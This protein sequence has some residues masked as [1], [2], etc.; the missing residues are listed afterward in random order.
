[1]GATAD[2][3]TISSIPNKRYY[4]WLWNGIPVSGTIAIRLQANN[5]GAANYAL[6]SSVNGAAESTAGN[7]SGRF[8]F[9]HTTSSDPSFGIGTIAN[10]ST[11]EKLA[12]HHSTDSGG[13]GAAS[14]PNRRQEVG[15]WANTV[16]A[17]SSLQGINISG[18]D[19]DIGTEFVLLGWDPTDTHSPS[20][21]FW[22][23]LADDILGVTTS[24]F[25]SSVFTAR[26]YLWIQAY[27]LS[28]GGTTIS[29]RFN[30]DAGTNYAYRI[31][32]NGGADA[33]FTTQTFGSVDNIGTFAD[34]KFVNIYIV[35]TSTREKLAI[36]HMNHQSTVGAGAAPDRAESVFKWDNLVSQITQVTM[37]NTTINDYLAGS[38]I[39]VWG[40]D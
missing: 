40:H 34:P 32:N 26:K 37:H 24:D 29:P 12:M 5:D 36:G 30:L 20:S 33:T 28:N 39:R 10:F 9:L 21:N 31:A 22:Q 1:M 38:F 16:A 6:R 4:L 8:V 23:P 27:L 17:I 35:N 18:G 14:A 25:T 13:A 3:I 11:R 15:K 7:Q 2:T 19:M